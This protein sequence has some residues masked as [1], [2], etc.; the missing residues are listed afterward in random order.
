MLL[1]AALVLSPDFYLHYITIKVSEVYKITT[2][3]FLPCNYS[4]EML[5]VQSLVSFVHTHL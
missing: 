3:V 4:L 1:V 2:Y 5:F